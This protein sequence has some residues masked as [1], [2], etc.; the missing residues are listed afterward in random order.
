MPP[1]LSSVNPKSVCTR[2]ILRQRRLIHH[3]TDWEFS[4]PQYSKLSQR[5]LLSL[6]GPDA[7][8]FLQG[9]ITQN[10][11]T[12]LEKPIYTAFLNAQG[13]VLND[14][15]IYPPRPTPT[16]T[17]EEFLV[18]VDSAEAQNLYKHLKKHK[19]RSKFKIRILD[20]GE[21][22]I[23]NIRNA[24]DPLTLPWASWS[25]N[26]R[27]NVDSPV[28]WFADPR[29]EM[30]LRAIQSGSSTSLQDTLAEGIGEEVPETVYTTW[31]TLNGYAEGQREIPSG[32]A[33]PQESNI[34]LFGGIDFRKGCYLGQELTIR[35]HHT[36]VVRKR[37]LPVQFGTEASPLFTDQK[38]PHFHVP[39]TD[40]NHD[41]TI[42]GANISRT[43]AR[44]GRS[45]GRI[46]SRIGN[47]G[48]AL[49][50]LE[51]MTDLKLTEDSAAGYDPEQEFKATWGDSAVGGQQEVKVKAFVP[52]WMRRGI[53]LTGVRSASSRESPDLGKNIEADV[54]PDGD[55]EELTTPHGMYQRVA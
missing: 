40:T 50:R 39:P 28:S 6:E 5:A 54:G 29:P 26:R 8:Q 30:G 11:L 3:S 51:M 42:I 20:P 47:V 33:L 22:Q 21:K 52:R 53:I 34:D 4:T 13:R 1:R 12:N 46:L 2:C 44:K 16:N 23:W 31:R 19:L 43:G 32:A 15:F 38:Q 45:A 17:A 41:P 25:P 24:P 37:I 27:S 35:T 18:E 49:C 36:G 10:I 48:L 9:L 14:V 55:G 7:G